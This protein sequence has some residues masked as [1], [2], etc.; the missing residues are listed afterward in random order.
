MAESHLCNVQQQSQELI[1]GFSRSEDENLHVRSQ[2][3]AHVHSKSDAMLRNFL[4]KVYKKCT[5]ICLAS[6]LMNI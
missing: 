1:L 4:M 5:Q 3:R 6:M 2:W